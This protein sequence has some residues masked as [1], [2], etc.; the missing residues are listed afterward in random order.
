MAVAQ[1]LWPEA[2]PPRTRRTAQ[3]P[4]IVVQLVAILN[5]EPKKKHGS[6]F[7]SGRKAPIVPQMFVLST[8]NLIEII[9]N[10]HVEFR[11]V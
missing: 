4:G 1:A 7:G 11:K 9:P 2:G 8:F 10:Q 5:F 6:K 3:Q